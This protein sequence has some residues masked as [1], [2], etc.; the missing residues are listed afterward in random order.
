MIDIHKFSFK[1]ASWSFLLLGIGH[2]IT[3]LTSPKTIEQE[4]LIVEMKAFSI[5]I[6]GSETSVYSFHLG[7]SL[8]MGLLLFGYGFLNLLI[9]KDKQERNIASSIIVFNLVISAISLLLSI[10]YFFIVPVV[11]TSISLF[12]YSIAF[13]TKKKIA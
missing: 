7:F 10:K 13:I 4:K 8:M 6:A 2:T 5:Q 1:L 12:A 3:D 11:F 9:T